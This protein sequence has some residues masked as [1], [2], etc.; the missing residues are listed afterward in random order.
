MLEDEMDKAEDY[1]NPH[2]K[3]VRIQIFKSNKENGAKPETA[4]VT[5][6][7]L[8]FSTVTTVLATILLL[9]YH[10]DNH[11]MMNRTY[12]VMVTCTFSYS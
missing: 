10:A 11:D 5:P 2:K 8:Q 7:S 6:V 1:S 9:S 3:S 4:S 12:A